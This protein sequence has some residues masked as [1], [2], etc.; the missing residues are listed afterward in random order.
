MLSSIV[1][2]LRFLASFLPS[3]FCRPDEWHDWWRANFNRLHKNTDTDDDYYWCANWERWRSTP[4]R[5]TTPKKKGFFKFSRTPT[6]TRTRPHKA[7][8]RG[9]GDGWGDDNDRTRSWSGG[10]DW[11]SGFRDWSRG[12]WTRSMS[13]R[14]VCFLWVL[15]SHP[16]RVEKYVN[17]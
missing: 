9:S 16:C 11:R 2:A 17:R 5:T 8:M 1:Y 14:P 6:R 7:G 13:K 15:S 4:T 3:L 10:D 12:K